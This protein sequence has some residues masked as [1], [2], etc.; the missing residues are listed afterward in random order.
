M[1]ELNDLVSIPAFEKKEFMRSFTKEHRQLFLAHAEFERDVLPKA[2]KVKGKLVLPPDFDAQAFCSKHGVSLE[3]LDAWLRGERLPFMTRV[4]REAEKRGFFNA[5]LSYGAG[6]AL[7]E[8]T[9]F[10]TYSGKLNFAEDGSRS[11]VLLKAPSS[12]AFALIKSALSELKVPKKKIRIRKVKTME[13]VAR[14]VRVD[15]DVLARALA[16]MRVPVGVQRKSFLTDGG[17]FPHLE[18]GYSEGEPWRSHLGALLSVSGRVLPSEEKIEFSLPAVSASSEQTVRSACERFVKKLKQRLDTVFSYR[19]E[20]E[21]NTFRP[22]FEVTGSDYQEFSAKYPWLLRWTRFVEEW[23]P[24]VRPPSGIKRFFCT[25][26]NV[27]ENARVWG[28]ASGYRYLTPVQ[29]AQVLRQYLNVFKVL[30]PETP[31]EERRKTIL[32]WLKRSNFPSS[33]DKKFLKSK[34]EDKNHGGEVCGKKVRIFSFDESTVLHEGVHA[35]LRSRFKAGED[36]KPLATAVETFVFN[37][38]QNPGFL[39]KDKRVY[40]L[41]RS[42]DFDSLDIRTAPE[43][44][45]D[46]CSPG[47]VKEI[48]EN[49]YALGVL[50]GWKALELKDRFGEEAGRRFLRYLMQG[51]GTKAARER[52]EQEFQ[53]S[54]SGK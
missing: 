48:Q 32:T 44:G 42:L 9:A 30:S 45:K 33:V 22:V 18:A 17:N 39:E 40:D 7:N 10:T 54:S 13:G 28:E 46:K 15:D 14:F 36:Y 5:Y 49:A 1:R 19:V 38:K 16:V 29:R 34:E 43:Y 50:L 6:K 27:A 21:G 2:R 23:N 31:R 41:A 25:R 8:L 3:K 4:M 26:D 12:N 24:A 47:K 52:V 51:L 11:S 37:Q 20:R 35:F 53:A